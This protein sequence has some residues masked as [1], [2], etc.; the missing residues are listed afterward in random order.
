MLNTDKF[1]IDTTTINV[2]VLM[3]GPSSENEISLQSGQAISDALSSEGFSVR[4]ITFSNPAR[5]ILDKNMH[6]VFPALHGNYG[7]DGQLQKVLEDNKIAYVGCDSY[8][9]SIII[10]KHLSKLTLLRAG[11]PLLPWK[12]V[13]SVD[14]VFPENL[15]FPIILK[16]N[17][18]GSTIGQSVINNQN[19]WEIFLKK[20]LPCESNMIAESYFKGIEITV[21]LIN[22]KS[23]PIVEIIP[24]GDLFDFDAKYKFNNGIT[25]YICPPKNLPV[26]QQNKIK[27]LAELIYYTL[28]A[29]DMLRVDMLLDQKTFA[30]YVLE[31]NSIPGFT[32]SSL[33]PKAAEIAGIPFSKLCKDLVI[34]AY[35]RNYYNMSSFR[36]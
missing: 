14:Q 2:A 16:P 22:G 1:P 5:L 25:E 30:P 27:S 36:Q 4:E 29:R 20:S 19:E 10:N 9:N 7:E 13:T 12:L 15:S 21:G 24:P 32:Q 18:G 6:V 35:S 3:G 34:S 28:N 23:L 31:A 11:V 8:S 33:L 17:T 26:E